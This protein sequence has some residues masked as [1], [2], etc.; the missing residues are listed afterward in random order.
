MAPNGYANGAQPPVAVKGLPM[1]T[2]LFINNEFVSAKAGKTFKSINPRTEEVIAEFQCA[3][4]ADVDAAVD[5]AEK[6]FKTWKKSSGSERRDMLLKLAD[7]VEKHRDQLAEMES[8]D[9]GKPK[10]VADGVDIGFV[11]ECY[12]YYAGWADKGGGKVINTTRDSGSTLALTL[13]EP[14]GV[15]GQ[16]IP[17]NFPLLMQAWKIGPAMAMGCTVVMNLSEKTPLTG[18]MMCHL[19]KEAGFPPGVVN[20]L[21]GPG[22]T[23]DMIARHMDIAKVAFTGSSAVG[24]KIIVAAGQTNMKKVTLELGGKSPLIICKDADLDQAAVAAHVGL[25]INAGQCCCA[26]S[27]LFVHEDVHDAFLEKV[28][29]HAKKR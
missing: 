11:I 4:Q 23:G 9:N 20:M 5:A 19:I 28:M 25:F 13:H 22:A 18:M 15:C 8:M 29:M 21:N 24:H 17:W 12:K 16:I 2:R 27:R 1:E 3:E 14:I 26:S 7:L 10:H 6:A